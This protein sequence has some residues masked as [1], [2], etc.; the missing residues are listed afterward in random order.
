MNAIWKGFTR[1]LLKETSGLDKYFL[2]VERRATPC[3]ADS[4]ALILQVDLIYC[5]YVMGYGAR[6]ERCPCK[7][8]VDI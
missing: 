2:L 7:Y 6:T 4:E 8:V 1:S 3:V 5:F